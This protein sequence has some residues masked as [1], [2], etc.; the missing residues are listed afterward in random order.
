MQ[1]RTK[2]I[3]LLLGAFAI[4]GLAMAML[5]IFK[6]VDPGDVFAI[7]LFLLLIGVR[8]LLGVLIGKAAQRR[9]RG[10]AGWVVCSLIFGP[11]IVWIAYLIFVH[12]RPPVLLP[13]LR[14]DTYPVPAEAEELPGENQTNG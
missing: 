14:Q 7:V 5:G 1:Y 3:L 10:Y 12:S 13:A 11:L 9:G 2:T 4:M 6:S 8:Y